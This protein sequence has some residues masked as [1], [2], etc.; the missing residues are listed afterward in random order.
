V[1]RGFGFVHHSRTVYCRAVPNPNIFTIRHFVIA[2]L[3]APH[4]WSELVHTLVK[5]L[6]AALARLSLP[7]L[8]LLWA[9]DVWT[10][11]GGEE[12]FSLKALDCACVGFAQQL[13]IASLV[14]QEIVG[15]VR[16]VREREL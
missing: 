1:L 15:L 5:Q 8:P 3:Q 4:E 9:A 2:V 6:P 12:A 11:T 16:H 13:E 10:G 14:A 7:A